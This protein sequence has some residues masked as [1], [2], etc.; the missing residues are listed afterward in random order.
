MIATYD[1]DQVWSVTNGQLHGSCGNLAA[2]LLH[3]LLCQTKSPPDPCVSHQ[4]QWILTVV[5]QERYQGTAVQTGL[6]CMTPWA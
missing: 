4:M 2:F 3:D 1:V 5:S 6:W